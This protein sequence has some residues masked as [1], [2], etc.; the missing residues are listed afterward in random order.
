V[1]EIPYDKIIFNNRLGPKKYLKNSDRVK[2]LK[3]RSIIKTGALE[4]IA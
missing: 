3:R 4:K 2:S 1:D